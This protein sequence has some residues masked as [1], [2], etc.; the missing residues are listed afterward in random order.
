MHDARRGQTNGVPATEFP[1]AFE[2]RYRRAAR[3][4]GV[5]ERTAWLTIEG[6]DLT[7]RFGP[8]RV[9]T[10]L[11]N[12]SSVTRTGPYAFIKTAGPAR[13]GVV[14]RSLTFAT[15]GRAG[16]QIEFLEPIT[17]IDPFGAIHH[18]SLTVTPVDCAALVAALEGGPAVSER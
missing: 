1:F 17:G 10:S 15:N 18:Q 11:G 5:T 7:V 14:E 3:L 12:I 4:F 16:V 9:V 13:L 8:W 6:R 2:P